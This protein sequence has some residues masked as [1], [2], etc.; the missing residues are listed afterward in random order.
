M[1]IPKYGEGT[2]IV[3]EI[4]SEERVVEVIETGKKR[5]IIYNSTNYFYPYVEK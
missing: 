2:K 5:E 3:D 1:Y 4:I